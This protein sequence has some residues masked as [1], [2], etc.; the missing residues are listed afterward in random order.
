[1]ARRR[2]RASMREGPLADL[3]RSTSTSPTTRPRLRAPAARPAAGGRADRRARSAGDVPPARRA[4]RR[5]QASRGAPASRPEPS[6]RRRL[7]SL[8]QRPER[9]FGSPPV[10]APRYGARIPPTTAR[11]R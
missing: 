7:A 2:K 1:M 6:D 10:R 8:L 3:F 4:R 11:Q 5:G 9:L